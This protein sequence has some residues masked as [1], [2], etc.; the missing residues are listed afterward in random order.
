MWKHR[1]DPS[2]ILRML[3]YTSDYLR[4]RKASLLATYIVGALCLV[5][6][7]EA[8]WPPN[9]RATLVST[10]IGVMVLATAAVGT[11]AMSY[12]LRMKR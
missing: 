2:S 6:S 8:L 5:A 3:S 10:V 9:L 11:V 1:K 7:V 4:G 12:R